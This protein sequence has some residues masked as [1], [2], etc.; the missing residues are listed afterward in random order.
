MSSHTTKKHNNR[1][2][3]KQPVIFS[4]TRSIRKM[5]TYIGN[6]NEKNMEEFSKY[7]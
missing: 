4:K 5:K 7:K 2:Y 1:T 6:R 3:N